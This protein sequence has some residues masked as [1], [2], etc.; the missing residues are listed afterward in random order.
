MDNLGSDIWDLLDLNLSIKN[1]CF[2][3]ISQVFKWKKKNGR[4]ESLKVASSCNYPTTKQCH[5]LMPWFVLRFVTTPASAPLLKTS[6]FP[7]LSR[8]NVVLKIHSNPVWPS[9]QP[10]PLVSTNT[11]LCSSQADISMLYSLLSIPLSMKVFSGQ[12][13]FL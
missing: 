10:F 5:S 7:V 2:Q 4:V 11:V 12:F 1:L 9:F 6:V 8:Q 13:T 3:K